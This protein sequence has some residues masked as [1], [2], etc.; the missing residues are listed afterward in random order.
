MTV[1]RKENDDTKVLSVMSGPRCYTAVKDRPS[2]RCWPTDSR[3]VV[4]APN[5]EDFVDGQNIKQWS[6]HQQTTADNHHQATP[7]C[8]KARIPGAGWENRG[9]K[10]ARGRQRLTFLGWLERS[11]DIK[12]LDL[13]TKLQPLQE[14]DVCGCRQRQDSGMTPG[15]H[16][17]CL[18]LKRPEDAI[19]HET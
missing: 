13:I 3:S 15:L 14:N 7:F 16:W 2:A 10:R 12:P 6:Q 11:T 9:Q 8:W 5:D 1:I 4:S 18:W 17:K 19:F